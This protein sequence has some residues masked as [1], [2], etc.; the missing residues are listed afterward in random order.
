MEN[1]VVL[2][3]RAI[4]FMKHFPAGAEQDLMIL[5]GHLLIEELLTEILS[6][7]LENDNPVNIEVG[8]NTMFAV[9][10]NLCWALNKTGL[11]HLV[12]SSLK[13]LNSIR[14]SMAHSVTPVGIDSKIS[15]FVESILPHTDFK[16]ENY[17]GRELAYC[18]MW[19]QAHV[20]TW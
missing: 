3:E 15:K 7:S 2:A 10:L 20:S 8:R 19:L 13:E 14:N 5:K 16:F 12:W 6:T 1:Q 18:I 11:S 4:R 9:K 17:K